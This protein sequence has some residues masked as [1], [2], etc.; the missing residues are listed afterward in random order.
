M[1]IKIKPS[2]I[3]PGAFSDERVVVVGSQAVVV[4]AEKI[5]D[6]LLEV[7]LQGVLYVRSAETGQIEAIVG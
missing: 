6:G 1:R 7:D 4:S 5:V 3:S 2:S